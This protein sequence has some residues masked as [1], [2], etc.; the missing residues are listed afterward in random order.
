MKLSSLLC[1][2]KM[3]SRVQISSV[4][5][6]EARS[7]E[8]VDNAVPL[9]E[10]V[11]FKN[12]P[13]ELMGCVLSYCDF[14]SLVI[15]SRVSRDYES[16]CKDMVKS[17]LT[18]FKSSFSKIHEHHYII[19][20]IDNIVNWIDVNPLRDL[21]KTT[22]SSFRQLEQINSI[23]QQNRVNAII[24]QMIQQLDSEDVIKVISAISVLGGLKERERS[25]PALINMLEQSWL[26]KMIFL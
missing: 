23:E 21:I 7:P 6:S 4:Q 18:Q 12:L 15:F 2:T 9:D 19:T 1:C 10:Q 17:Q 24:T 8:G 16:A 14:G 26:K 13:P 20:S 5:L 25:L 3:S 11:S 22:P